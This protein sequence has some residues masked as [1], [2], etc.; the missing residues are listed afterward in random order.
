[1]PSTYTT[2]NGI[3]LPATGEQSGTWGDTVNTNMSIVD[4]LVTGVGT[5]TLSGTTHTL[6]TTSGTLSDGMY[7]V[8]VFSGSPSGT[9]TVTISPNT[10][11]KYYIVKNSSGQSVVLTQGSG[12]NVTVANGD[13][14]IV[15]ANG[16]GASAAVVDLTA[17]L[18]MSSVNITGGT[19]DGSVIGG[20]SAAAGT[21]TTATVVANT[22][23]DAV[24]ITQTG[25]G[26]ALVVED[27]ANP[28][29]TPTVITRDGDVIIG[30]TAAI[31]SFQYSNPQLFVMGG[32]AGIQKGGQYTLVFSNDASGPSVELGKSRSTTVGVV[33]TIV[34]DGDTLG[35]ISFNGD[36]GTDLRTPGAT[37]RAQVDGTPGTN[38][39]PG[40]LIFSTTPDGASTPTERMRI[41]S[42]GNIGI[43]TAGTEPFTIRNL[44][45]FSGAT[46]AY[47]IS[48]GGEIQS[49]VTNSV[50]VNHTAPT[51]QAA[52]FTLGSVYHY[53]ANS[54]TIGLGSTVNNQY[55]FFAQ[56]SLNTA[57]NNYGFYGNIASGTGRWNF[58][59][60]GTAA[61]YFAGQVQLGAGTA[62][63]PAL[64]TTGD[65][66]TGFY[67]PAADTIAVATS[68]TERMRIDSSGNVGIGT[69]SPGQKLTVA[70]TVE[71]T[72][73]GF[74]FPDGTT[75]SSAASS[76]TFPEFLT[77]NAGV[78]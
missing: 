51:T 57:T 39:M 73:G 34:Q 11:Q 37:I 72:S 67:F 26:N 47:G 19:I 3:E 68:G 20:S 28:D 66:N 22:A 40:R 5:I 58:Y 49:G 78:I 75:Q 4:R 7:R 31:P 23:S 46:S 35:I 14:K 29:S 45:N 60:N 38:D 50:F 43:G 1:M 54:L 33:G 10:Q 6:T 30:G 41:G 9:N 74:K 53:A 56:S 59:A 16:G 61:N 25:T 8:L 76:S 42:T 65:T 12:G 48:Q 44:R 32:S 70:G 24:R 62:A 63:E 2:N 71:S 55:G 21:F 27:S 52:T 69:S 77:L 17:D 13:V 15:Y 36:D 18:A 64:S